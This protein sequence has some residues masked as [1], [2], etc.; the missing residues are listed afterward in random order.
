[1]AENII[2]IGDTF[3]IWLLFLFWN[4]DISAMNANFCENYR[5]NQWILDENYKKP[6]MCVSTNGKKRW[7]NVVWWM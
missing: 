1:M 4:R 7:K 5:W 2:L 6:T 3:E